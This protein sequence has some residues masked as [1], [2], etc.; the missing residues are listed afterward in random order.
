MLLNTLADSFNAQINTKLQSNASAM[1]SLQAQNTALQASYARLQSELS[2]LS[3]L[4]AAIETNTRILHE[5]M[6][7]ADRVMSD[8]KHRKRPEVDDVLVAP[9]VVAGQ[10]YR[11]AGEVE[12][13]KETRVVLGR[14]LDGGV[15]GAA[16]FVKVLRA[17]ARE[18]FL[19]KALIRK[20]GRGLGLD[21]VENR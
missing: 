9:T 12:G 14:G 21:E 5:T 17:T 10:L 13:L 18:E 15:V 1:E 7:E 16:E 20:I 11:E 4:D 3:G 19:K 2:H 6:R 8:A